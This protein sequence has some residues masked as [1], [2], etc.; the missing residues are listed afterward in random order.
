MIEN[1]S[2]F[3]LLQEIL[4]PNRWQ[5]TVACI[6]LNRTKRAQVDKVWPTLFEIAPGP[7][8]LLELDQEKLREI[9]A[10]LGLSKVRSSRLKKIARE[11]SE[12]RDFSTLTGVGEYA[13]ASDQIFYQGT[14]P[15]NVNDHA[16]KSYVNWKRNLIL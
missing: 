9:L 14:L 1:P 16:L 11:W 5:S 10:P 2:P 12:E 6:L 7:A 3:L 8:E 4:W 13:L 15:E